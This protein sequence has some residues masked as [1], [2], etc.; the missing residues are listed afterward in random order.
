MWSEI[1]RSLL[2]FRTL[3]QMITTKILLLKDSLDL[4]FYRIHVCVLNPIT[5]GVHFVG[6]RNL[7][8]RFI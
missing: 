4:V 2:E 3:D 7:S 5:S 6:Y 1:T 8:E